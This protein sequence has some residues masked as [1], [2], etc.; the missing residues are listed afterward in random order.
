M[1][2]THDIYGDHAFCCESGSKTRAHN[3]I[4]MDFAGALSPVLSQASYLF[5]NTPMT[6]K[7]LFHLHSDST[8][9]PFDISF[10][11][12]PT[13]CHYCPTPLLGQTSTSPEPH[14]HP[15]NTNLKTFST[16]A[17]ADNN[18]QRHEHGKLGRMHKSSTPTTPFIHGDDVIG[19][20]YQKNGPY[21]FHH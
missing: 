9:H 21:P 17:N 4:A 6:V 7:Q 14:L 20:L 15:R 11:P 1:T 19:E 10:S 12:H 2:M 18:L 5:P 16:H 3:I 13:A 8:A